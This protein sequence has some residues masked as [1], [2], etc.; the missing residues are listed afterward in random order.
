MQMSCHFARSASLYLIY[1]D[2]KTRPKVV[3]IHQVRCPYV[4]AVFLA[5][6]PPELGHTVTTKQHQCYKEVQKKQSAAWSHC[7]ISFILGLLR[8]KATAQSRC[9][10]TFLKAGIFFFIVTDIEPIL[11]VLTGVNHCVVNR[12]QKKT[13]KKIQGPDWLVS[14]THGLVS[15]IQHDLVIYSVEKNKSGRCLL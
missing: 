4:F 13:K 1:A 2:I 6:R 12:K 15:V 14:F 8:N 3:A 7:S 5:A 10:V 9:Y 11:C